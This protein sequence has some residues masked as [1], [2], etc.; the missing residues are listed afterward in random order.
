MD[1]RS[2]RRLAWAR[3]A[4][5]LRMPQESTTAELA[6][7]L[8]PVPTVLRLLTS[9]RSTTRISRTIA[10]ITTALTLK[11]VPCMP[12]TEGRSEPVY[13]FRR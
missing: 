2:S 6:A 12:V 11:T 5:N 1:I 9:T 4:A 10:R 8:A 13:R 7:V 3:P